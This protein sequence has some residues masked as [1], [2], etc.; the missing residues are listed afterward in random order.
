MAE[1]ISRNTGN[2]S[3]RR[4]IDRL[5]YRDLSLDAFIR[6]IL[7]L[8][9]SV[10]RTKVDEWRLAL[11]S[12]SDGH[13]DDEREGFYARLEAFAKASTRLERCVAFQAL[14]NHIIDLAEKFSLCTE[15]LNS[16]AIHVRSN[17]EDGGPHVFFVHDDLCEPASRSLKRPLEWHYPGSVVHFDC[18]GAHETKERLMDVNT[19]KRKILGDTTNMEL[20]PRGPHEVSGL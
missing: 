17:G 6:V 2:E 18:T 13:G 7:D 5:A 15:E 11:A 8:D 4:A 1:D 19:E 12:Y 20:K 9:I 3:Y 10:A 16:H 14:S